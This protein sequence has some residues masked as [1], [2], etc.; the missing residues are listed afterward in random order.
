MWGGRGERGAEKR[1]DKTFLGQWE[2]EIEVD[3]TCQKGRRAG[4]SKRYS[5]SARSSEPDAGIVA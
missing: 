4:S 3:R 1:K 5:S 2:L